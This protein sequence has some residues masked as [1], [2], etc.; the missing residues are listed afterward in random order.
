MPSSLNGPRRSILLDARRW[1]FFG[2]LMPPSNLSNSDR[3]VGFMTRLRSTAGSP[4]A[5]GNA[6]GDVE[7]AGFEYDLPVDRGKGANESAGGGTGQGSSGQSQPQTSTGGDA[8]ENSNLVSAWMDRL[9]VLTVVTTFLASMDGQLFSLTTL[10]SNVTL[11]T[12]T[13]CQ[14]LVYA[15]LS[16]A[17]IF[18]VCAS[19]LG[20]LASF[21]L[22]KYTIIEASPPSN[23]DDKLGGILS[24]PSSKAYTTNDV[25]VAQAQPQPRKRVI[26]ETRHPLRAFRAPATSFSVQSHQPITPPIALL[27]RCYYTTLALTALGFILALMG[28][29]AYIWAGLKMPVGVFS[30]ICLGIG[31]G[32]GVW[33][34]S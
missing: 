4:L 9:Q 3:D 23:E 17:L 19:I 33:S 21:V 31:I 24:S 14:E 11:G 32:A 15:S 5:G 1:P 12:T 7:Q 30:T 10:P 26:V 27:T 16:G 8:E 13:A 28:I 25:V 22:I 34:I 29:L 18:H 2:G 20:Y 6:G